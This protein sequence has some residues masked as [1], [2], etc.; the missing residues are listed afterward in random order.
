MD[1]QPEFR[2][3]YWG[4]TGSFVR[5]IQS[6]ELTARLTAALRQLLTESTWQELAAIAAS[7]DSLRALLETRLPRHI[8]STYGGNTWC[9]EI[10]TPDELLVLDAGSGLRNLG[11]ELH[12]RWNSPGYAGPR[13]AN[14]LLTH[15][16]LDHLCS[17][18][19]V[20]PLYDPRNQIIVWAPQ[21]VLD[22]LQAL[23]GA[24]SPL[25]QVFFP[26]TFAEMPGVTEFR[27]IEPGRT[28]CIGQTEVTA[29]ALRHPG[30]CVAYRLE[31]GRRRIVLA[32]DHEHSAVPD[33]NL[34][35]FSRGADLFCCDAQYTLDE[36]EGRLGIGDT[37]P[38]SRQGWGHSTV[39]AAVAT[40]L[41]AGAKQ[42][43]LVHH[44]PA[45]SD[46]DLSRLEQHA[47]RLLGEAL[48]AVGKP[49]DACSVGLA[50]EGLT[51]EI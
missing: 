14:L 6:D 43:H 13:R 49:A 32:S 37:P 7:E 45:R 39:E 16:H 21:R 38:Q 46:E 25:S 48:A 20:G 30:D 19:F 36:Y 51:L 24:G 3:C 27:S 17:L 9:V 8:S 42:L 40:A 26:L 1:H 10:V 44:D 50:H 5:S 22:N 12:R 35:D 15:A 47:G 23:L 29:F 11:W 41:A 31:R 33:Q 2:I 28:C 18:P 34:A 4:V